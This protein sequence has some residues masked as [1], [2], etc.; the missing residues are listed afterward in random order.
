TVE[1]SCQRIVD[2]E[3]SAIHIDRVKTDRRTVDK[4]DELVALVTNHRLHFMTGGD[5][6]NIPESVTGSAGNRIDRDVEP[7]GGTAM[8]VAQRQRRY[9]LHSGGS[10]VAQALEIGD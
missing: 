5:V 3:K 6:L 7:A 4:L 9:R 8:R 1:P 10:P 2:E